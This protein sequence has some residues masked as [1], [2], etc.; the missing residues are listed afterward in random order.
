MNWVKK[1]YLDV[2]GEEGDELVPIP[3]FRNGIVIYDHDCDICRIL[4]QEPLT[5]IVGSIILIGDLHVERARYYFDKNEDYWVT[6]V[7]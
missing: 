4:Y 1:Y 5:N 3:F 2:L 7:N 6:L